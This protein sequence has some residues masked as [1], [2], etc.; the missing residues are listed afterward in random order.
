MITFLCTNSI[1]IIVLASALPLFL[2]SVL[3]V[4][5]WGEFF[6]DDLTTHLYG[7]F[8]G[9]GNLHY[10]AIYNN[11]ADITHIEFVKKFKNPFVV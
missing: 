2:F 6:A 10:S 7:I 8:R 5:F 4:V 3:L 1:I 11:A 9:G